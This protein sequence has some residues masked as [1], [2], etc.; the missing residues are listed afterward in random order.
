M[1]RQFIVE[2]GPDVSHEGL[3]KLASLAT[4]LGLTV[5]ERT[6]QLIGMNDLRRT[7][8]DMWGDPAYG[9]FAGGML[10]H[11]RRDVDRTSAVIAK[12]GFVHVR[13]SRFG[14]HEDRTVIGTVGMG[15]KEIDYET[16][17]V[18]A[19]SGA[20]FPFAINRTHHRGTEI[21]KIK[22]LSPTKER[23]AAFVE[24]RLLD[25]HVLHGAVGKALDVL[26]ITAGLKIEERDSREWRGEFLE[27]TTLLEMLKAENIGAT[28]VENLFRMVE[29]TLL[30]Q[31]Q[32][33]RPKEYEVVV[34]A[35]ST[36]NPDRAI[37]LQW[38]R[39]ALESLVSI[40]EAKA[41][42]KRCTRINEFLT[43]IHEHHYNWLAQ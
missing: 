15:D 12:D 32:F 41:C 39:I 27:R 23:L 43:D 40:G 2:V 13:A 4:E 11:M 18:L 29:D 16:Q 21:R 3:Q 38:E 17:E 19:K 8:L 34:E 31:Q 33:G 7:S 6:E 25:Q 5:I 24:T 20:P 35:D 26:A 36:I 28:S 1:D 30:W 22:A 10:E 37:S 9:A 14:L 42:G